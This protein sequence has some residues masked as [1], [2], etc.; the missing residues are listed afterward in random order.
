MDRQQ[1]GFMIIYKTNDWLEAIWE[2][3][4][5]RTA[6]SLLKRM[7]I[8][9]I[10]ITLIVIA[11]LNF[12][13]LRLKD[14]PASYMSTLGILLSLLLLF[15]TN[16]A[17]D[18]FYEGRRAWGTLVNTCRNI[19]VL[20][21]AVLPEN[22]QTNRL[23]FT[24]TLSNFPFALRNH[25]RTDSP[26]T[27]LDNDRPGDLE[28]L[29]RFDHLPMGLVSQLRDRIEQLYRTGVLSEAQSINLSDPINLLLDVAGICERIRSTPIP[30]S[31]SFFIKLFI[32]AYIMLLPFVVVTELGYLAIPAVLV[33]TYVMVGLEMIGE[34][35]EDPFGTERNDLPLT[36]LSQLIRVNVHDAFGFH[37]NRTEK[38]AARARYVVVN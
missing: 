16:T 1:T 25:L 27:D 2:F 14:V 8:A 37:L 34:E 33:T 6:R 15:R 11:E 22:D 19:A 18:R 13:D 12:M 30:F 3:H 24:K 17:Y 38:T 20:L 4:T 10:Y 9:A 26:F 5:G 35:I 23:F 29:G 7:A 21:N 36:Q 32:T 28:Q 31:Y